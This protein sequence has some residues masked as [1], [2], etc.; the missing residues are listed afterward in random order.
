MPIAPARF[1][2][3]TYHICKK[4]LDIN[5]N[6]NSKVYNYITMYDEALTAVQRLTDFG[7]RHVYPRNNFLDSCTSKQHIKNRHIF[8]QNCTCLNRWRFRWPIWHG[9]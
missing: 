2:G 6:N 1:V 3:Q 4:L 7:R 5:N 8:R 9:S